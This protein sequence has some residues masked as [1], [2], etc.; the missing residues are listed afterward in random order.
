MAYRYVFGPVR[1]GRLG[2]SLG[3][4]LTGDTVCTM[5]CVYCEVGRTTCLTTQRKPY[6]PAQDI[7]DELAHWKEQAHQEPDYVTLGG[8]GEP[9]LN[10]DM[11]AVIQ[12]IR[13]IFPHTPVAVLTNSTLLHDPQVR[14]ELALADAV[15]PSLDSLVP[16]ELRRVNRPHPEVDLSA[17]AQGLLDFRKEFTG[18][19]LLEVLLVAGYNDSDANLALLR[20]FI[21]GLGADRVDVV[22]MTRPGTLASASPVCDETLARWR[23]TLAP[24]A[25]GRP[26]DT[27]TPRPGGAR[28]FS[29]DAASA[30]GQGHPP[31][32]A[33][34]DSA[35]QERVT[36]SIERRPQT[37]AQLAQALDLPPEAV[38]R[39][40][41]ALATQGR[42]RTTASGGDA[43][44]ALRQG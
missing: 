7:L 8:K 9:T 43:Y 35:A 36:A 1:S 4:D 21:A 42:L 44:H 25:T 24:L 16:A 29:T 11:G 40:L 5:D 22:T 28:Q 33:D 10:S 12:G 23:A 27:T 19:L 13:R 31:R 37:A 15:L 26:G 20:Q 34:A 17:L 14:R 18:R 3:L 32:P 38:R 41:E 39:A 30:P 2:L 6:V